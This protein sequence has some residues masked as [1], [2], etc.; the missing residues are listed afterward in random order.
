MR[1][2]LTPSAPITTP[3]TADSRFIGSFAVAALE[4]LRP[5]R[6]RPAPAHPTPR[7]R[8]GA[9]L[10]TASS[11]ETP[12]PGTAQVSALPGAEPDLGA[13]RGEARRDGWFSGA[14]FVAALLPRLYVAL[15]WARE[16]V[17]DGHYD[18]EDFTPPPIH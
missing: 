10:V 11:T 3:K 2:K 17:W 15:A 6:R 4:S 8:Y 7:G 14:V 5:R 9:R 16:P 1:T 12:S 13:P 18:E